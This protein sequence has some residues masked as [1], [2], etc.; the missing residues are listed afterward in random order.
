MQPTPADVVTAEKV[1][2]DHV[3]ELGH[4]FLRVI[5]PDLDDLRALRCRVDRLIHV[6]QPTA[7]R[8]SPHV[9]AARTR[10]IPR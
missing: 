2:E 3:R 9:S 6:A 1:R 7:P 8:D 5:W 4:G 10:G